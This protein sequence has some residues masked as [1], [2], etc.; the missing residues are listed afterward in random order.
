MAAS[1]SDT[2]GYDVEFIT[3]PPFNVDCPI[4]LHVLKEPVQA[5]PCGHLFCKDCIN[6]YQQR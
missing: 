5:N 6:K 1:D 4:C 3:N 2:H